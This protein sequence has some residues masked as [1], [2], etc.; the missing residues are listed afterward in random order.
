MRIC[1][2][3]AGTVRAVYS[4]C[5]SLP[6]NPIVIVCSTEKLDLLKSGGAREGAGDCW[7]EAQE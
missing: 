1:C 6:V 5:G 2:I 4:G 3:Q 7:V